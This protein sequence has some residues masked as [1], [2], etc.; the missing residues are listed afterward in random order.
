MVETFSNPKKGWENGSNQYRS[1]VSA[2]LDEAHTEVAQ[3]P[4]PLGELIKLRRYV[5]EMRGMLLDTRA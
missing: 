1:Q 4:H 5:H 2:S 3:V